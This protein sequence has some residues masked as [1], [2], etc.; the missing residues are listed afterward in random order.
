MIKK[1]KIFNPITKRYY[2]VKLESSK[3]GKKGQI[4]GLWKKRNKL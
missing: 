4:K 3:H 2:K 1:K